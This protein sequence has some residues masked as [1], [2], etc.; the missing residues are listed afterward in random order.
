MQQFG[1]IILSIV[2]VRSHPKHSAEM[3]TQALFGDTFLITQQENEWS[4]VRFMHDGYEGWIH[5]KQWQSV[6]IEK[7]KKFKYNKC[8]KGTL[9][10]NKEKINLPIGARLWHP[11]KK[12]DSFFVYKLNKKIKTVDPFCTTQPK[13]IVRTAKK[14]LGVPYLW[15]GRTHS[16][17]DCSGLVQ[18]VFQVNGYQLPRDAYQQ[19]ETGYEVPL[20]EA[21][22]G[23]LAFFASDS[24]KITHVGIIISGKKEDKKIIHA[25]GK[26][27][28]DPLDSTGIRING[29]EEETEYSHQLRYIKRIID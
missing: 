10:I 24:D 18:V 3:V 5:N 28:I 17:I 26:V 23:D 20:E 21:A 7:L 27:R 14:F 29:N 2:P 22:T 9:K 16:G 4:R 19:A 11:G 13:K 25:S 6:D 1:I 12:D 15:G 8:E